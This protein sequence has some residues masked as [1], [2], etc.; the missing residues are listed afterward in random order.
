ME[1]FGT[2]MKYSAL[3]SCSELIISLLEV[4][5]SLWGGQLVF[6]WYPFPNF[7]SVCPACEGMS[8]LSHLL[9]C[10]PGTLRSLP[11]LTVIL[12]RDW[13]GTELAG[14]IASCTGRLDGVRSDGV[15]SESCS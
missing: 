9:F 13:G 15:G 3:V 6:L 5:T 10:F 1:D 4:C 12:K 14:D 7:V 2:L 11:R 8:Y